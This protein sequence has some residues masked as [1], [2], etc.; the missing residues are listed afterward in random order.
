M[1]GIAKGTNSFAYSPFSESH[2]FESRY[3][4][5]CFDSRKHKHCTLVVLRDASFIAYD[6]AFEGK[7]SFN[8][9]GEIL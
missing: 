3:G 5:F 9:N 4:L 6:I 1:I 8:S 7:L 2:E